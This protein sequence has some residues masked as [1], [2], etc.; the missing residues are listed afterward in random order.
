VKDSNPKLIEL[1]MNQSVEHKILEKVVR[2]LTNTQLFKLLN[3][4]NGS[5]HLTLDLQKLVVAQ[6]TKNKESKSIVWSTYHSTSNIARS[7]GQGF[8][9]K[10]RPFFLLKDV[11]LQP[12]IVPWRSRRY[13]QGAIEFFI[14]RDQANFILESRNSLPQSLKQFTNLL[15]LRIGTN[16]SSRVQEDDVPVDNFLVQVNDETVPHRKIPNPLSNDKLEEMHQQAGMSA[17]YPS[18]RQQ[19]PIE[20]MQ[21][22]VLSPLKVVKSK[23]EEKIIWDHSE[24]RYSEYVLLI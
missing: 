15:Q 8:K 23:N 10:S 13:Q 12:T 21:Y 9:F 20:I 11:L 2:E 7:S 18:R 5:R 16:D 4:H 24:T 17:S 6:I 22:G 14:S 1:D 3:V 19:N